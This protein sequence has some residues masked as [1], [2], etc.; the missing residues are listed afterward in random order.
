MR[1]HLTTETYM[2][3]EAFWKV[4]ASEF[5]I[6]RSGD[7]SHT[8]LLQTSSNCFKAEHSDQKSQAMETF[9]MAQLGQVISVVGVVQLV[10]AVS[11]KLQQVLKG[12]VVAA[13][14]I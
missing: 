2:I 11:T 5:K 10:T 12:T 4:G 7:S 13:T 1:V 6:T 9:V 3:S 14:F 8:A